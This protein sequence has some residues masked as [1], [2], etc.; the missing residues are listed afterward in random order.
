M[1]LSSPARNRLKC[2]F[3]VLWTSLKIT[4]YH[5]STP[6]S[7][8][9]IHQLQF[10]FAA[11]DWEVCKYPVCLL[12]SANPMKRQNQ[13]WTELFL[14]ST[15]CVV[16]CICAIELHCCQKTTSLSHSVAEDSTLMTMNTATV[17]YFGSIPHSPSWC[18]KYSQ[19]QWMCIYPLL[20]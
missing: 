17:V 8:G 15:A 14:T 6:P 10:Q 3:V 18:L 16:W 7:C 2:F 19:G 9:H 12:L 20:K 11:K 13:Q 5:R 1:L 4:A